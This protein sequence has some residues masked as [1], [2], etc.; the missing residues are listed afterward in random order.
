M[1]EKL[2]NNL[3]IKTFSSI[4]EN[5]VTLIEVNWFYSDF[6]QKP[7]KMLAS[8]S[9]SENGENKNKS[10]AFYYYLSR[11]SKLKLP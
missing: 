3:P 6:G 4:S 2:W 1:A 9:P 7:S 11:R 8:V 10:K 5:L